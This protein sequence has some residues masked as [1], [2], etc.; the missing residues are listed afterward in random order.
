[1]HYAVFIKHKPSTLFGVCVVRHN[2]LNL[3][4]WRTNSEVD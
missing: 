2:A 1:M 3:D 4:E